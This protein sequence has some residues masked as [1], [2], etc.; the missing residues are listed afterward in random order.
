MW[1][2]ET[3]AKKISNLGFMYLFSSEFDR[4]NLNRCNN[5]TNKEQKKGEKKLS[6]TN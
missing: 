2:N 5:K 4:A 3:C 6:S 1:A